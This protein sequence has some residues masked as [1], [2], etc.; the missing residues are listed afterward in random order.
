MA[1]PRGMRRAAPA[2]TRVATWT[3]AVVFVLPPHAALTRTG[4]LWAPTPFED[5][6]EPAQVV[7]AQTYEAARAV[8]ATPGSGNHPILLLGNSRI[9]LPARPT[10]LRAALARRSTGTPPPIFNLGIFGT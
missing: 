7:T 6:R 3:L 9:W 5:T 8:Y 2:A 10:Y 4:V 1:T